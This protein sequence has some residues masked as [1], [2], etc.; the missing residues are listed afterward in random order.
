MT[1]PKYMLSKHLVKNNKT[2]KGIVTYRMQGRTQIIP[3]LTCHPGKNGNSQQM[4]ARPPPT[5][6]LIQCCL[7]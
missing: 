7:G 6:P 4:N 5:L 2:K 1:T 3:T